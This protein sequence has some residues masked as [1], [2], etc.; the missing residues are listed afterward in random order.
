[1]NN[2]NLS[3]EIAIDLKEVRKMGYELG[4][5]VTMGVASAVF[6]INLGIGVVKALKRRADKKAGSKEETK[7]ED[8]PE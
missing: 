5:G 2:E 6:V 8:I 1:M 4:Y 7:T 3:F